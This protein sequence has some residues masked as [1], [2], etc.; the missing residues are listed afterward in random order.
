M[1]HAAPGCRLAVDVVIASASQ[2]A[3]C[4]GKVGKAFKNGRVVMP[5]T[6]FNN[7]LPDGAFVTARSR[8]FERLKLR[9][10]TARRTRTGRP[11]ARPWTGR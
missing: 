5:L 4:K 3:E 9:P 2:I 1:R 6:T 10:S 7:L 11:G 8:E